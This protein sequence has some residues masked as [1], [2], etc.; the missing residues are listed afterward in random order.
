MKA[1][2]LWMIKT[3]NDKRFWNFPSRS[4]G[5]IIKRCRSLTPVIFGSDVVTID[6]LKSS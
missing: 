3:L 4:T 2:I 1:E 5:K 6:L